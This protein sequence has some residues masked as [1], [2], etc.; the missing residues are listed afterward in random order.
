MNKEKNIPYIFGSM[1]GSLIVISCWLK[2]LNDYLLSVICGILIYIVFVLIIKLI[3]SLCTIGNNNRPKDYKNLIHILAYGLQL[4]FISPDYI[5][6]RL[7]KDVIHD[8][9][10]RDRKK[11]IWCFN[12]LNIIL[13]VSFSLIFSIVFT[14]NKDKNSFINTILLI[15]LNYRIVSRTIEII[16]SFIADV[17]IKKHISNLVNNERIQL[18][19]LSLLEIVILTFGVGYCCGI[20]KGY[21]ISDAACNALIIINS[22]P[23]TNCFCNISNIS[24]I[25]CGLSSFSLIGIVIGSYLN[26]D[27]ISNKNLLEDVPQLYIVFDDDVV[28]IKC[29]E[30]TEKIGIYKIVIISE[31]DYSFIVKDK[32]EYI[33]K[34]DYSKF[35]EVKGQNNHN[36]MLDNGM[37][38]IIYDSVNKNILEINK[39]DKHENMEGE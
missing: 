24:K 7:C 32:K 29:F 21:S 19:F 30:I 9:K 17:C 35:K 28:N 12:L 27:N 38:E 33:D 11:I 20:N 15:I 25:F 1:F 2:V 6:T 5:I 4:F 23:N 10:G 31:R 22:L 34:Q 26:S 18:A 3:V 16:I 37:Y 8:V 13:S 36:F 39:K 14:F